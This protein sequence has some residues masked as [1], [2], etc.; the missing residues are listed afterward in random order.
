VLEHLARRARSICGGKNSLKL[1][2]LVRVVSNGRPEGVRCSSWKHP[3]SYANYARRRVG[4]DWRFNPEAIDEWRESRTNRF[5]VV[6]PQ[7]TS[8]RK[9]PTIDRR[10]AESARNV[11]MGL[12][13]WDWGFSAAVRGRGGGSREHI[14]DSVYRDRCSSCGWSHRWILK[15]IQVSRYQ[16]QTNRK[17]KIVPCDC[18]GGL[19]LR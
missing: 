13:T 15:G 12:L 19:L 3:T 11:S 18:S 8:A 4:S 2:P 14:G 7:P 16:A 5:E 10:R 1:V 9:R 17:L 6:S